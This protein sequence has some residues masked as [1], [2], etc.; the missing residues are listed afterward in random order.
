MR[1]SFSAILANLEHIRTFVEQSARILNVPE[2]AIDDVILAVDEAVTN[3]ILHG[4]AGKDGMIE[5]QM[6]CQGSALIV[7]LRDQAPPFDPSNVPGPDLNLGLEHRRPGGLGVY[8]IRQLMDQIQYRALAQGGNEL[9][10][11]KL[12]TREENS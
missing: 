6:E 9:I 7:R 2:M 11:V 5:I 8:F 3:I 4:Y 1:A 12:F 10:L